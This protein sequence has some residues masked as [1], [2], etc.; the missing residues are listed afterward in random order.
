M[1]HQ[2]KSLFPPVSSLGF[3]SE[4]SSVVVGGVHDAR[5]TCQFE[6][7]ENDEEKRNVHSSSK[8]LFY[9][10]MGKAQGGC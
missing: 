6:N 7:T 5:N 4:C 10:P 8:T 1:E 9:V 2:S 3:K